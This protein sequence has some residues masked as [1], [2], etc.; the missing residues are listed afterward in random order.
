MEWLMAGDTAK[1]LKRTGRQ[2]GIAVQGGCRIKMI[3]D[4]VLVDDHAVRNALGP[5]LAS[6]LRQPATAVGPVFAG[7]DTGALAPGAPIPPTHVR[8]IRA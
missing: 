8:D 4:Q 2:G 1:A 3:D 7:L 5:S 6:S